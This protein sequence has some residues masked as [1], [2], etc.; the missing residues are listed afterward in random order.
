MTVKQELPSQLDSL[1][2]WGFH[3][4]WGANYQLLLHVQSSLHVGAILRAH[5]LTT[6]ALNLFTS[7]TNPNCPAA[8]HLLPLLSSLLALLSL[9]ASASLVRSLIHSQGSKSNFQG[10]PRAY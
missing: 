4:G 7:S 8:S 6:F 10:F 3:L 9:S 1:C 5:E 2:P